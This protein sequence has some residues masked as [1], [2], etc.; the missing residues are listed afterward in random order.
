MVV[1]RPSF[2]AR[3]KKFQTQDPEIVDFALEQ[4]KEFVA[5]SLWGQRRDT[6]IMLL[7][8]HFLEME[9]AQTAETG[10]RAIAMAS[11][12][13]SSSP[14]AQQDDFQLTT[15][16]RRYKMLKDELLAGTLS[17]RV[18]DEDEW[19]GNIKFGIGFP[20]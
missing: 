8:A 18:D 13:G 3:Y 11:G 16:G 19:D 6:G 5:T 14:S 4:A 2:L 10:G 20:I 15:Y 12:S 1:T 7:M 17:P 9:D